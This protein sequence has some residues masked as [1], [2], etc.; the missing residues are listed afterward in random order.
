MY[1]QRRIFRGNI[2]LLSINKGT[3]IFKSDTNKGENKKQITNKEEV[4]DNRY[5]IF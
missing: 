2:H 3:W 1:K 5:K 4:T